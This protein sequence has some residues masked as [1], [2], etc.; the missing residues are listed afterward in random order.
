LS[1]LLV[2]GIWLSELFDW[3]AFLSMLATGGLLIASRIVAM[4]GKRTCES[5]LLCLSVIGLGASLW[6]VRNSGEDRLDIEQL[7]ED[8]QIDSESSVRLIGTIDNIP[9]LDSVFDSGRRGTSGSQPLRTLFLVRAQAL[10]REN[11]VVRVRGLCRVL[12]EGDGTSLL[13]WG[14]VVELT[15]QIDRAQ[16]PLNPGEFDFAQHLHRSGVSVMMFLKHP[17]AVR[18]LETASWTPKALLTAFRQHTVAALKRCL[19]PDNR[20]TAE[21]LL[22]GNRGHLTPDLERDFV[23]SGTVH[24]LAISGLHVGILYVF[25]MRVQNVLLIA[26]PRAL[27]FAGLVCVLYCLLTDLRPSVMRA[28]VFI[29]LHILGQFLCRDVRMG[30]LIGTTTVLLIAYDPSLAFSVGAWLSFLAVGALGWVS[31][32]A[33]VPQDRAVPLDRITWRDHLRDWRIRG[34]ELLALRYRQMLSVTILSAPLVAT[35]FHMVSLTGMLINVLLIPLTAFTLIVGYVFIAINATLSPL[36]GLPGWTFEMMLSVLNRL[37]AL[38]ADVRCG[39]LNIPDLPSWFLPVYFGLLLLSVLSSHPTVRHSLRL[40]LLTLVTGLL[41]FVCRI[42][43]PGE[44]VC[45]V[46]SVGHGNAVVVETPEGK[47]LLFDAGALNRGERTA[48]LISRFLWSRGYR[49]IDAIVVSHADADH[50]NA[51]ASLLDRMPVGQVM[52]TAEF[53]KSRATEVHRV[54][55]SIAVLNLP[56]RLV[57][58]GDGIELGQLQIRFLQAHLADSEEDDN[59]SSLVAVLEFANHR[60]CLP[61]DLEGA[62][63]AQLLNSLPTCDLLVSP[64]HGSPAANPRSL[65]EQVL[66]KYVAVS[67]RDDRNSDAC[68]KTY[69]AS[70]VILCCQSGAV[71][72]RI[73]PNGKTSLH[74][75][76]D[77]VR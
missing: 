33:P 17:A 9:A 76:R 56:C 5:L 19:S 18:R 74:T 68:R 22:L 55:E 21:A 51:V 59:E 23:A 42:P 67:S 35:Q 77:G 12:M 14:D 63:L 36:A 60:I 7:V 50:Y 29:V 54:L 27:I 49:M 48:D 57:M 6:T 46:L 26:R 28:T 39:F 66:P 11:G 58:H 72:Y 30:S 8:K 41:Y 65:A 4:S 38:S 47:V 40:G 70:D 2:S 1:A 43:S 64:H 71:T 15:G 61:G 3:T 32:S 45:T 10:R 53:A 25:L 20:A 16:P 13:K 73:A 34:G 75:F 31:E 44:L 69:A 52:L 62:G 24:L 37:V